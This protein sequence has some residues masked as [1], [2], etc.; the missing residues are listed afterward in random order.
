ML[1]G[2]MERPL[3]AANVTRIGS[4][5]PMILS[6]KALETL[7]QAAL[8][9]PSGDNTQPWR[10]RAD[11]AAGRLD[12]LESESDDRSA[13][14]A[15]QHMSRMAVGAAVEN[16]LRQA[17]TI[18]LQ[19]ELVP[20]APGADAS[21]R[22][23]G[24]PGKLEGVRDPVLFARATNRR[25]Y[26]GRSVPSRILDELRDATPP[27]RDVTTSWIVDRKRI[28]SLARVVGHADAL[29]FESRA[30]LREL[31]AS[32]RFDL[33]PE[34]SVPTGLS[35][36][37]LEMSGLDRTLLRLL[38]PL[39]PLLLKAA[40]TY[41]FAASRT[42]R[43]VRSAAGLCLGVAT[44]DGSATDLV[45]GRA[46][47]RAWLALTAAGLACQPLM[48]LVGFQNALEPEVEDEPGI[49]R[50]LPALGSE[51]RAAAPE[52]GAGHA[53]FLMRFGYAPPP[54]GRSGRRPLADVMVPPAHES[55]R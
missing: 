44:S 27:L 33:P 8:W 3:N 42:G 18:G 17:R 4:T 52:I 16:V 12:I 37:S 23:K 39:P 5:T 48:A 13:M 40:G 20:P 2:T 34:E 24:D 36:A 41:R 46:M 54:S 14:N 21:I 7:L 29:F 19:A 55:S 28:S 30:R 31:V 32:V 25:R 50:R 35:V 1:N 9:A 6:E 38:P 10:F 45:A 47:Q 15:G 26:D 22:F 43:L 11:K 51:L 49:R 53:C